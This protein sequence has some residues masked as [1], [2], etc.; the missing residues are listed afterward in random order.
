MGRSEERQ[1]RGRRKN[2]LERFQGSAQNNPLVHLIHGARALPLFRRQAG[3]AEQARAGFLED[4][5]HG[6]KF[7]PP[8]AK[9]ALRRASICW[10]VSA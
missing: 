6:T 4:V 2:I 9:K 7:D 5:G 1:R 3:E 10:L 8:F